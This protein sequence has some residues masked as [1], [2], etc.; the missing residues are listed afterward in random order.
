MLFSDPVS[1]SAQSV[2]TV[3]PWFTRTVIAVGAVEPSLA[4]LVTSGYPISSSSFNN[5][6][7]YCGAGH[8]K[9]PYNKQ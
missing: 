1:C 9:Y 6:G 7:Y 8:R 3:I 5:D 4:C 2:A